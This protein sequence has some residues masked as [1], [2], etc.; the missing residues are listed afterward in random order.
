MW[1][2][3]ANFVV[4]SVT[5]TFFYCLCNVNRTS[6]R[7]FFNMDVLYSYDWMYTHRKHP[8]CWFIYKSCS[9]SEKT[10]WA[11]RDTK[12][13]KLWAKLVKR[14]TPPPPRVLSN[15]VINNCFQMQQQN[16]N[17]T[18]YQLLVW[19]EKLVWRRQNIIVDSH[20]DL[21]E[22]KTTFTFFTQ[23]AEQH[24]CP[25]ITGVTIT[26]QQKYN[27]MQKNKK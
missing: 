18:W 3:R 9:S 5:K 4:C 14:N 25:K 6:E 27:H 23:D 7:D 11:G 15:W 1:P 20:T 12:Q 26:G 17:R 19:A 24:K 10:N 2:I 22:I 13:T 8:A 16:M 21:Y